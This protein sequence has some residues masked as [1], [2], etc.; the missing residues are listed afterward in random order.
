MPKPKKPVPPP[1][2]TAP[3][4]FVKPLPHADSPTLAADSVEYAPTKT[5]AE[6]EKAGH[7]LTESDVKAMKGLWRCD[8]DG[9]LN[10]GKRCTTCGTERK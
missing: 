8:V 9:Q 3:G 5:L 2:V 6:A 7:T 1:A 4:G 10:S